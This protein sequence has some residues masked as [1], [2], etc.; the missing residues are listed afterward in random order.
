MTE[1]QKRKL[2]QKLWDIHTDGMFPQQI[3]N[4]RV[5]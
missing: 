4:N 5:R 3:I 2:E 1:E